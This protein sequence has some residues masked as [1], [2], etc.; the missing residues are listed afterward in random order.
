MLTPL[1]LCCT[2]WRQAGGLTPGTRG[3]C[4]P[5]AI[6]ITFFLEVAPGGT[7]TRPDRQAGRGWEAGGDA[8]GKGCNQ[9]LTVPQRR[10]PSPLPR[11][12]FSPR[13]PERG[14][15]VSQAA[16]LSL[17]RPSAPHRPGRRAAAAGGVPGRGAEGPC[18]GVPG[19]PARPATL[20]LRHR[21]RAL[22]ARRRYAERPPA[23]P[24]ACRARGRAD[25]RPAPRI[26]P[27]A[28]EGAGRES[29]AVC[30]VPG[31]GGSR[32]GSALPSRLCR[33]LA[34]QLCGN[35]GLGPARA[36]PHACMALRAMR[37]RGGRRLRY[38]GRG[39]ALGLGPGAL[40]IAQRYSGLAPV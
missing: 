10:Y 36:V 6:A 16:P 15:L 9:Q 22:A 12:L 17:G 35:Q 37:N 38:P 32:S 14:S 39:A 8:E 1:L 40:H 13:P 7:L 11:W 23:P 4:Q 3:S 24:A 34:A 19:G 26:R 5:G 27:G 33:L 31:A 20:P 30:A 21:P 28:M 18:Q 2:R 29:Y 25:R